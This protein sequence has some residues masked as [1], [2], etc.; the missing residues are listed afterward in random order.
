[1]K[2]LHIT[3]DM[4]IGGTEMVIKNIIEGN[5]PDDITMSIYCLETPLGPWG[6]ALQ[7]DGIEI[8]TTPRQP[9]FDTRLI[10]AIRQHIKQHNIDIV[11]CHQYTPW[12]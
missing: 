2:V 1:M 12:V 8:T 10:K 9:G 5:N 6:K 4:R 7:Q 11:H 3:Y